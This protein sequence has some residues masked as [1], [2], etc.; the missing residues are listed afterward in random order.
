MRPGV[1]RVLAKCQA[2]VD[3]NNF[4]E[5]HQMYRTL[6]FRYNA[7]KKYEDAL[8]LL[9][10][11]SLTLLKHNQQSSG[12]D[13]ASLYI[14]TLQ[15]SGS[16]VSDEPVSKIANLFECMEAD[17]P[18]RQTYLLECINWSIKVDPIYKSGH[19]V[20]HKKF[21]LIFWTEKNY[22][23]ARY[24]FLHS[25]DGASTAALLIEYHVSQGF[26]TEVDLFIAQAVLQFLCL[27]N[28]DTA[29]VVFMKYTKE[30]PDLKEDPP[31]FKPL[32]NFIW[33]LLLALETGKVSVFTVLCEKYETSINRDPTYKEYLDR[34][35]QLFFGLPPP[36]HSPHGMFGNILQSLFSGDDS[37]LDSAMGS[38]GLEVTTEELD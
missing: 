27:Q 7:Q 21:G 17:N 31:F 1:S 23:Q 33:F 16:P 34:I 10:T 3:E 25:T 19:P 38:S 28:K 9:Y 30:H 14:N 4:Y 18:E 26:P 15:T 32:L 6:Y 2:C 24:H 13:L 37:D 11:G 22:A 5:A 20:L 36:K 29:N 35:G 8:E 12:T